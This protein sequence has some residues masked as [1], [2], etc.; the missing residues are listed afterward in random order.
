ISQPN[1]IG[2]FKH[3]SFLDVHVY[4]LHNSARS[5]MAR[6]EADVVSAGDGEDLEGDPSADPG[7]D[8]AMQ[9]AEELL[10]GQH[11]ERPAPNPPNAPSKEVG[12]GVIR[13]I[14]LKR[15][16][17]LVTDNQQTLWEQTYA[18]GISR[19]IDR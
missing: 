19:S 6:V 10:V 9:C 15:E 7:L 5:L 1:G 8:V 3:L 16:E 17:E 11:P 4:F 14:E 13:H 18:V 12:S 2:G